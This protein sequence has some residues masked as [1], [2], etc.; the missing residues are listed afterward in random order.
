MILYPED[1]EK[2]WPAFSRHVKNFMASGKNE[3]DDAEDAL[4]MV[5]E[6]EQ[7]KGYKIDYV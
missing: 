4:T 2:R 1:W 3:H 5:I 7:R 6:A